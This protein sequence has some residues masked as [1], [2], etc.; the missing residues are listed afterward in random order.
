MK[1]LKELLETVYVAYKRRTDAKLSISLGI[2]W[3]IDDLAHRDIIKFSDRTRLRKFLIH[4]HPNGE[5]D[6]K[7]YFWEP[8]NT[9]ARLNWLQEQIRLCEV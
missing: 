4:N 7:K 2:C 6:L 9:Q 3:T 5:K 1:T 8:S